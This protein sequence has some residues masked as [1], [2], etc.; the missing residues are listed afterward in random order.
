ML[1][2][3]SILSALCLFRASAGS[4]AICF[5]SDCDV[6]LFGTA[7]SEYLIETN[8]KVVAAH[9]KCQPSNGLVKSHWKTMVQMGCAY[10]TKNQM[11][12]TYWFYAITHAARMMNAIL[13]K[14]LGYLASPFLLVHGI[15]HDERTWIPLFS[16]CYFHHIR[17][18]NQKCSKHQAHTMDGI[19]I[20]H[21]LTLNALLVY[22]LRNKQYYELDSYHLDSYRLTS[23]Y[24]DIRYDGSLFCSLVHDDNP[25]MEEKYPPGTR[26]E[27]MDPATNMLLAGTVMNIPFST[28][29]SNSGGPSQDESYSIL[30]SNGTSASIPLSEMAGIIPLPPVVS[31]PH[32]TFTSLDSLS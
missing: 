9:T 12:R 6:K 5:Y 18:G 14:N 4:L 1:T 24:P 30:F 15:G 22:N 27:R 31:P 16:L 11:P 19:V 26:V 13:G 3:D 21:S 2:S 8:S 10:L 20:G 17:D 7:I 32:P 29:D 25:P 23:V 28:T